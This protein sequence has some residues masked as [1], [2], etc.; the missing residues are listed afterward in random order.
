M[1]VKQRG[2]KR[3]AGIKPRPE[4]TFMTE[5]EKAWL[6]GII[7]G[8]GCIW[9]R[10]PKRKNVHVEVKMC[11][12]ATVE[13]IQQLYPGRFVKGRLSGMS[14]KPQWLWS[15]DTNGA[16][17]LLTLVLPYMVTKREQA[18]IAIQLAD[19]KTPRPMHIL[20]VRLRE[21]NA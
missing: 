3:G 16:R 10:F 5:T 17:E 8:E 13:R 1:P 21:L 4:S 18:E 14:L 11:H 2:R 19:R 6:A 7:D 20:T 12:K 15:L 9:T